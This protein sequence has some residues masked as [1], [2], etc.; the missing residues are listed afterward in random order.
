MLSK[1]FLDRPVFAWVIAIILMTAGALAIYN[2]PISQYPPIAPPTIAIEA[3]YP[4]ASAE[5][6]EN[7]VT[8]IIEQKMTGFDNLL[9]ISATSDS[10]G[11]GR[12]ELT[13]DP[14]TDPDLAW[15][16]VQNK[17]QLAM[18]SLPE[19]VQRQ[20]V[21]VRKSTRNYL[22]IISLI[23]EDGSMDG[24]DLRDYAQ[25][26]LEQVLARVPGVG[27]VNT[28]GSQYAM[29]VW[30]NP[31][32]L[33]D[34]R[35]TVADVIA[36]L[37]VYNV[38][39]SA[40]QFG[41]APA[42]EGQR[43]NASIIVQ[44]MLKTPEEF[45]AVPL[46]SN[47]D[48][49]VV[50]ISD[51]ARVELGTETYDVVAL[52][53][54]KPASG[55]AIRQAAGANALDTSKAIRAKMEELSRFFPP[56][57]TV[58]YPY[59]SSPFVAVAIEEV[60]KT[61]FEAVFLVFLVM[62][63]FLGSIR[64][65]L[66]PTIAVPVVI[67]GTFAV[68]GLFGFSINML[69]MFAMVLAIGLLVDDAIV[70]VEN[71]ERIMAE[72]GLPPREATAKSMD[73]ITSALIGI[74]LVLSAVFGPMAFFP[75]STGVIYRQ[76]SITIIAAMLLSVVVALI[77]TPVLC[78][79]LLKPVPAGHEPADNAVFFLRPFFRWF[80][81]FFFKARE[82]YL[83]L[84]SHSLGRRLRYVALFGV[85]V[86]AMAYLFVRMP[87]AYLPDEDQ[88]TLY[89]QALLPANSTLEQTQ[90][91]LAK[92]RDH[93][94]KN[95]KEAV[96]S[97]LT[98]AGFSFAGRGQN[99]GIAWVRLRDWELRDRPELRVK[100]VA[101][102]ASA[103]FSRIREAMVFAFPPPAVTELG[104]S[105]GFD[106]QLLDR[107]GMGHD[108]LMAARNQLLGMAA[109]DPRLTKVRPNGL[110]DVPEYRIDV[111]WEKAGAMG[112]P[113][114]S[115]HHTVA[116]AFGSAYVND[117][118][119]RGRVKRVYV[120][121]DAPYR[122]LPKDLENL[123]VRNTTGKMV[124]FSSFASGHWTIGPPKLERFNGFPSI[125]IWGEP[126][127]GRSSGEAMKAMEDFVARLPQGAGYDWSGLS[128][129]ER[130]AGSQAP[131]LYAFSIFVIF[132]CLAALYESW[133]IPLSILLTLPLGAIGGVI[134]TSMMGLPNDVYFQIGLLTILGL[135]TKNAILIVQ[136]ARARV[137]EGMRVRAA[138]LEGARLRLR[139][140]VMTSLAFGFGV[141]PLAVAS[142]A[143]AGAQRAI[144]IGVLGGVVTS[145]FLVTLFAPLFYV[146][147]YKALGKHRK[148]EK[149]EEA[150]SSH[151]KS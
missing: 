24:H 139:P 67:L 95:E 143:G 113:V 137:D 109:Q 150:E 92:V 35:M 104:Q 62:Y 18:A 101:A 119:H 59:D 146:M 138:T 8:Q 134:A 27:E 72:E 91:V 12:I 88:G 31:E 7:S 100:A 115:I 111:D 133:P 96:E 114:D 34:Y 78:A 103:A 145:T 97:C 29:R 15:A 20:G 2:L 127:E 132:L 93:F 117:F 107:G 80:D 149:T 71:V 68:L 63:V 16:E 55:L 44:N 26:N 140:I 5:T 122:M 6:V 148:R 151:A 123:Y 82:L 64:A 54:G 94:E 47:P 135:T 118:I 136:F 120:Q 65:T 98:V 33:T 66:I 77:L 36:A 1:F 10:S 142:G 45:A 124:P 49:S 125:N 106:F 105:K 38:E 87:T 42:V 58:V 60:V 131:L 147:V 110:E 102:R 116:A 56:G 23:S 89:V 25:S 14:G 22:M 108:N 76:F 81:R 144:G 84:V 112:V 61:L 128:Y 69:T 46:R 75:G 21:T 99:G 30:L 13:F 57:I 11:G 79:S 121:A 53:N 74:G 70:V 73:E 129:Q 48:G 17:L 43:L 83:K 130:M 32:K 51:V 9:Y 90:A 39:I 37:R 141:L 19:V 126:A 50:R 41:G 52:Y 86:A 28:F 4:G 85:I 40:G 3:F